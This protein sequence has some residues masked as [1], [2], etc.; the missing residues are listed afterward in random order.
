M[1]WGPKTSSS[2]LIDFGEI[3]PILTVSIHIY[4]EKPCSAQAALVH[5][6]WIDFHSTRHLPPGKIHHN[7]LWK[8]YKK[9]VANIASVWWWWSV[10]FKTDQI[11][12]LTFPLSSLKVSSEDIIFQLKFSNSLRIFYDAGVSE[13]DGWFDALKDHFVRSP[14]EDYPEIIIFSIVRKTR[15]NIWD[16]FLCH[17]SLVCTS[18]LFGWQKGWISNIFRK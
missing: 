6:F 12:L 10:M 9:T 15:M 5:F 7:T 11:L 8:Y 17:I 4:T 1:A 3:F 14:K 2:D 18:L 16:K 13:K